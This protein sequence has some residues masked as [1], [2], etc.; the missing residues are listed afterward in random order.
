M[1]VER[2]D[3]VDEKRKAIFTHP[4]WNKTNHNLAVDAVVAHSW[5][6]SCSN[7]KGAVCKFVVK[8]VIAV[9]FRIV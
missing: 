9:T 8:P 7:V 4:S 3:L 6:L 2:T 5:S 1:K